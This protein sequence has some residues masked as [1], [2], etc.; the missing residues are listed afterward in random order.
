MRLFNPSAA[1]PAPGT[2]IET[3]NELNCL[4]RE[5]HGKEMAVE[6]A[7]TLDRLRHFC[8][9]ASPTLAVVAFSH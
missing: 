6:M 3:G 7:R 2:E 4:S 1:H 8:P 5:R 9:N